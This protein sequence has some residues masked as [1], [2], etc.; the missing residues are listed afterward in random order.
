M[1]STR[2]FAF[3][4]I[5]HVIWLREVITRYS[6]FTSFNPYHSLTMLRLIIQVI[7]R[8]FLHKLRVKEP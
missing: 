6:S 1:P 2:N 8:A 5:I 4:F 3:N 7:N